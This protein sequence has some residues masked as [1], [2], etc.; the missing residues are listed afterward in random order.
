MR[1]RIGNLSAVNSAFE[2]QDRTV[3]YFTSPLNS[4]GWGTVAKSATTAYLCYL[5]QWGQGKYPSLAALQVSEKYMMQ[6]GSNEGSGIT[7]L[8]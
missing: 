8:W 3:P 6:S 1:S 2:E 7:V 4:G 5:E